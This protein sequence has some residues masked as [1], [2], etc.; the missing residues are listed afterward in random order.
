M[1]LSFFGALMLRAFS[2]A[3]FSSRT[4][5]NPPLKE[6]VEDWRE[7]TSLEGSLLAKQEWTT[8]GPGQD[9]LTALRTGRL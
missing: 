9:F 4:R 7:V 1:P 6:I 3:A 2:L 8:G 5:P